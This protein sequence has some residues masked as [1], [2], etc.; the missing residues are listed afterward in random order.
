MELKIY[1]SSLERKGIVENFRSLIWLRKYYEP[2]TFELHVPLTETNLSLLG[3]GTIITKNES[4]EAGIIEDIRL[5][6]DPED[7]EMIVS[8]RFL[9]SLFDR[10]LVK[11][12]FSFTGLTET[13]MHT[14]VNN[15]TSIPL[16]ED[17]TTHGYAPTVTFQVT[18]KELLAVLTKLSKAS[19]I[20]YRLYP[21]F[22][23]KK[24]IFQ[25]YVG[26][27]RSLS[28][29]AN[30]RVIFSEGFQNLS[31][32]EYTRNDQLL[33]TYAVVGGEGKGSNRVYVEVGGG[34][35]LD[36][37]EVFVDAKDVRSDQ[38]ATTEKYRE[39]LQQRG[40]NKL[41]SSI[42][43]ESI[44]FE[45]IPNS[46]FIYK[47]NYDL[48]DIVTVQKESWGIDIDYRVTEIQETYENGGM[49]VSLTLGNALPDR[50]EWEDEEA[51]EAE[52][53]TKVSELENDAGYVT[54]ADG[55]IHV[56]IVS[57]S[58]SDIDTITA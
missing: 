56:D 4:E 17:G 30:E 8:G 21:D 28:Q 11:N 1:S 15:V 31:G 34:T 5:S 18:M 52:V 43:A 22:A 29:S 19:G 2:G 16:V 49:T 3:M 42:E 14:L 53:P 46:N 50:V 58:T 51:E 47:E 38:F 44:E 6:D 41:T 39:A 36:L 27:D 55:S 45:T 25:T 32:S 24:M 9:S 20:G 33:K 26:T 37:R 10:R 57:I 12:T 7:R 40:I 35:G 23:N 54:S 48:G 13:A